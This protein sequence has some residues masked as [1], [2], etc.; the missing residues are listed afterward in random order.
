MSYKV[1]KENKECYMCGDFNIDLLKYE[2]NKKY[3]EFLNSVTAFG[4]LPHILQPTRITEFT[5]T[6]IDNI[7]GNNFAHNTVGGNI[8][9][10]FA[11]HFSQFISVNKNV[12]KL[13]PKPIFRRDFSSF[14]DA[15]F[16]DDVSIQNWNAP[17]FTDTNS[18]F[19]DF[20][21]RLQGDM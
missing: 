10:T 2:N 21:W 9:I 16:I 11:D 18:K 19:N 12:Q 1:N 7:Y 14:K 6:L 8:L 5:S 13:K 15:D 3:S 17:N 4:L 20:L